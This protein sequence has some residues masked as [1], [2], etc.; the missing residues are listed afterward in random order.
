MNYKIIRPP[1]ANGFDL[2]TK[3]KLLEVQ[4]GDFIKLKFQ[5]E[6]DPIERMWVE[7]SSNDD[8]ENW[9]GTLNNDPTGA[10]T[11]EVLIDGTEIHFHPL[12]IIEI[13]NR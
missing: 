7:V 9:V 4:K 10:K 12:D 3:E 8:P 2:P 5:V 6:D 1:L 13:I 11:K